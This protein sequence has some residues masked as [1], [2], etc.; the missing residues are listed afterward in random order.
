MEVAHSLGSVTSGV[1]YCCTQL[2]IALPDKV[3]LPGSTSYL[4]TE[5]D[6]WSAFEADLSPACIVVPS[7]AQDTSVAV[8]LLSRYRDCK[9]AVK[10]GG[11]APAA[12]FANIEAGVT[13]DLRNLNSVQV[14]AERATAMVAAGA[15]WLDVYQA[16]DPLGL[17]VAGGRN[18]NVGVGGLVTGGGISYFSPRVGWACD[19]VLNFEIVISSGEIIN[20]NSTS[21][22]D[23]WRALKGGSNNFGIVTRFDLATFIQGDVWGGQLGFSIDNLDEVFEAFEGIASSAEYDP[24]TSIVT[25]VLFS[26]GWSISNLVTYTKA[27]ESP[28]LVL[29]PLLAIQPQIS[30]TLVNTNLST[31]TDEPSPSSLLFLSLLTISCCS[32][33][34]FQTGTYGVN[35]E[36]LSNSFEIINSTVYRLLSKTSSMVIWSIAYEPLSTAMTQYSK[37]KGG[38]SLG[39]TPSDGNAFILLISPFW[40][41]SSITNLVKS[42]AWEMINEIDRNATSMGL[43]Q[44]FLY[45]NYANQ[46]QDPLHS[47]GESNLEALRK[48]SMRYDPSG[49]FQ[50]QVPGGFKLWR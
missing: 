28:P 47:Y 39:V 42:A 23:L 5:A 45:L 16:L 44:D 49:V 22:S 10:G 1:E 34:D 43:K 6:Y 35:L 25:S 31:L 26:G 19:N 33:I 24:Y 48:A 30:N 46:M 21:N 40:T 7:S 36:L 38:N 3:Y 8:S 18:G 20:A 27:I 2:S 12:G 4:A 50:H 37:P 11:H 14:D 15:T 13:I 17:A 41:D 32:R 29:E 9:F